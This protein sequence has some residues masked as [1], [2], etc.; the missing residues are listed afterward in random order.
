MHQ[1]QAAYAL[2]PHTAAAADP[3]T[4][5]HVK[6]VDVWK[7]TSASRTP[8]QQYITVTWTAV[9]A[10]LGARWLRETSAGT[11]CNNM[12]GNRWSVRSTCRHITYSIASQRAAA[13]TTYRTERTAQPHVEAPF[14]SK[15]GPHGCSRRQRQHKVQGVGGKAQR[16][17]PGRCSASL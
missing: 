8:K 2:T 13:S 6:P 10:R 7:G 12:C 17:A 16:G 5:A 9:E 3:T 15:S 14:T 4:R 11:Y 1:G